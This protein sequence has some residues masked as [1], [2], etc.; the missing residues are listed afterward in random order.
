MIKNPTYGGYKQNVRKREKHSKIF[1]LLSWCVIN[2]LQKYTERVG[3][4]WIHELVCLIKNK[5]KSEFIIDAMEKFT[6]KNNLQEYLL[7]SMSPVAI[8]P[9]GS[10]ISSPSHGT[11]R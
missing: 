6:P 9:N 7:Q 8:V 5:I 1:E 10:K 3:S 11:L 2:I 4:Y